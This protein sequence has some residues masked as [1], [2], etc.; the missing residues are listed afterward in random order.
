[1]PAHQILCERDASMHIIQDKSAEKKLYCTSI[2]TSFSKVLYIL[3]SES[4]DLII[5]TK[6]KCHFPLRPALSRTKYFC[7]Y[8]SMC[9]RFTL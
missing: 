4:M 8:V 6:R 2:A 5:K 9:H 7:V 1:M 3:A